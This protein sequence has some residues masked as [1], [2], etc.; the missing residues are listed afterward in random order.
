M[1]W[2]RESRIVCV[3][4]SGINYAFRTTCKQSTS[5]ELGHAEAMAN[6]A[7]IGGAVIGSN[8]PKPGRASKPGATING[9]N[10]FYR[11]SLRA[12]LLAANWDLTLPQY[13][14]QRVSSPRS[15]LVKVGMDAKGIIVSFG[16]RMDMEQYTALGDSRSAL[17]IEDVAADDLSTTYFG[18]NKPRPRRVKKYITT[19]DGQGVTSTFVDQAKESNL[20][21]GWILVGDRGGKV[22]FIPT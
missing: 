16:W 11:F 7:L 20:P 21:E 4:M 6:G 12:T 13:S 22:G 10:S 18:I 5:T 19:A 2:G 1:P 3:P 17:G 9:E 8:S 14:A 15:K